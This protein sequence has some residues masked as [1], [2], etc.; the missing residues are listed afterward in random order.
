MRDS[1]FGD[2]FTFRISATWMLA[3][4]FTCFG[5]S[6]FGQVQA[7]P[8]YSVPDP[9][10]DSST[11][12]QPFVEL[13]EE[14]D[15]RRRLQFLFPNPQ[16]IFDGIAIGYVQTS[17]G[18]L[19]FERRDLV[20][21][22][23]KS[24]V[25]S[26]IYDSRL[27]SNTGF[28]LG[29]RLSLLESVEVKNSRAIYIDGNGAQHSFK[30]NDEFLYVPARSS[31]PFTD[32]TLSVIGSSAVLDMPDGSVRIFSQV[33]HSNA[34]RLSRHVSSD[35]VV[36]ALTYQ[37]LSLTEV[38]LSNE[39]VLYMGW[40]DNR[41]IGITDRHDRQVTYQYD[42]AG[43]LEVV[44]DIGGQSWRYGYDQDGRVNT[45]SHPNGDLYLTI[46]YDAT[47]KVRRSATT[48]EFEFS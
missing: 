26:R 23:R 27:A 6:G 25:A 12:L 42:D 44:T 36:V 45:A 21:L 39:P 5:V 40:R 35:G 1:E 13:L 9:T 17:A 33:G 47:G 20:V 46:E 7:L 38:S 29:W 15:H 24:I 10:P 48:R 30:R 34:Y 37:G 8:D 43:R 31:V 4:M 2:H 11:S 22:G 14:L 18:N 19:T 32:A 28:G 3:S 16:S 41:I